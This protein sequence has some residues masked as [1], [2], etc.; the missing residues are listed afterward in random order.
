M[1]STPMAFS[2]SKLGAMVA[3]EEIDIRDYQVIP[4]KGRL[5]QLTGMTH[6]PFKMIHLHQD[7]RKINIQVH[8]IPEERK[9]Y[10]NRMVYE[11]Y[12][13]EIE[14]YFSSKEKEKSSILVSNVEEENVATEHNP[15]A[16]HNYYLESE[17]SKDQ[18]DN[19]IGAE[20]NKNKKGQSLKDYLLSDF[21]DHEYKRKSIIDIYCYNRDYYVSLKRGKKVKS[22]AVAFFDWSCALLEEAQEI[23]TEAFRKL[24]YAEIVDEY[25]KNHYDNMPAGHLKKKKKKSTEKG[26]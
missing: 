1:K 13:S 23:P 4:F 14:A 26:F 15:Q 17:A 5:K 7:N 2:D 6:T 16:S 22:A 3:P 19:E 11:E 12:R 8:F 18:R 24:K 9:A 10:I 20:E 21:G 25:L